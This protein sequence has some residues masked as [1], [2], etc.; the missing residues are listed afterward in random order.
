MNLDDLIQLQV[1]KL[2]ATT[3]G[4]NA[5]RLLDRAIEE[6]QVPELRQMC[7]KVSPQLYEA[8]DNVCGLL[9]LSKRQFIEYAVAEAVH[10]A[11]EALQRS[12]AMQQ[13]EL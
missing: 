9:D 6:G 3:S 2:K 4:A 7:A 12:G 8:L 10:K 1:L 13:G 11:Q 5:S